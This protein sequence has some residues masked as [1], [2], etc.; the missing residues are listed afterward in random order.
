MTTTSSSRS[1][2][3]ALAGTRPPQKQQQQ[4]S[5]YTG[6][7]LRQWGRWAAE[8]RVPGTRQKLWIGTFETDRQ[9]ALAYDAAVFCFYGVHLP[10]R[11]RF[12]CPAAP[13]PDI[14][15]WV[16]VQLNVA[17]VKAIAE[18]HARAVDARLPPL[19]AAAGAGGPSAGGGASAP[20]PG[21][22][23]TDGMDDG[24]ALVAGPSAA[25]ESLCSAPAPSTTSNKCPPAGARR[26]LVA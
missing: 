18:R 25:D 16:R 5:E 24:E 23:R 3:A 13:R 11:R 17:S 19:V 12:N 14:P 8:V 4:S 20:P 26:E 10:R 21:D 6:V 15:A 7:R 1:S 2:R 9:A 22:D